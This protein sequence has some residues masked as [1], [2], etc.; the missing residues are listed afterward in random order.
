MPLPIVAVP[1]RASASF[2]VPLP[3]FG[4]IDASSVYLQ[5]IVLGPSIPS[6]LTNVTGDV[7]W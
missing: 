6:R 3:R 1:S 2:S 5:A 7:I 4:E